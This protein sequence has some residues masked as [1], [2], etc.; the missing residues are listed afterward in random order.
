MNRLLALLLFIFFTAAPNVVSASSFEGKVVGVSDGDTITVLTRDRQQIAVR[1]YGVDCPES[2]QAYGAR[3]KQFTSHAVF[4][5]HVTV[6]V[7]DVDRYGRAVGVVTTSDGTNLN[8]ELLA[9][10]MAWLYTK[11]CTSSVCREWKSVEQ[12]A[13]RS[14]IGLWR[15]P[16]AVPPWEYRKGQRVSSTPPPRAHNTIYTG[17]TRSGKFHSSRC[18]Y[19]NSRRCTA[20]FASRQEAIAAGYSP[21]RLCR[22]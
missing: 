2:S 8:R 22:P 18:K 13:K 1:V 16:H 7:Q 5:K 17:N 3:A 19:Y 12:K 4:K 10:G 11:Y 21:C 20:R 9:N 6:Q 15:D 14:K